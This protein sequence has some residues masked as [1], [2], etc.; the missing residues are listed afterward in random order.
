MTSYRMASRAH[1]HTQ[2]FASSTNKEKSVGLFTGQS[3][4]VS[5]HPQQRFCFWVLLKVLFFFFFKSL[6]PWDSSVGSDPPDPLAEPGRGDPLWLRVQLVDQPAQL[7]EGLVLVCVHDGGIEVVTE[8]VLHLPGLLDHLLQLLW[9]WN[10]TTRHLANMTECCTKTSH[11]GTGLHLCTLDTFGVL[12]W[13][14][15]RIRSRS[16]EGG[17][18]KMT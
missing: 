1:T 3:P 9:L 5:L 16:W 12:P 14:A 15:S 17:A 2:T 8:I 10:Q 6:S 4:S 11:W 13:A 18:M 7:V